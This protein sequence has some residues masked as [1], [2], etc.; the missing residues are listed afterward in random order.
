MSDN[1]KIIR[2]QA[3]ARGYLCRKQLAIFSRE[4][5]SDLNEM[6]KISAVSAKEV[7]TELDRLHK[8][9]CSL[10]EDIF[11]ILDMLNHRIQVLR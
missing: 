4:C 9:R 1:H 6:F 10:E 7:K 5:E 2:C 8:L 11:C 3:L